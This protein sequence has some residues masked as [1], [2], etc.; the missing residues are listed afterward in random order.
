MAEGDAIGAQ[1]G[2]AKT[3]DHAPKSPAAPEGDAVEKQD[4]SPTTDDEAGAMEEKED[5]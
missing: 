4:E 3:R 2:L 1:D 5:K